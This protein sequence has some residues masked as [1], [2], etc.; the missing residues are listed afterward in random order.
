MLKLTNCN[1]FD[2]IGLSLQSTDNPSVVGVALAIA[3]LL[4]EKYGVTIITGS[5]MEDNALIRLLKSKF[6]DCAIYSSSAA[7]IAETNLL[8]FCEMYEKGVDI[9]K[10]PGTIYLRNDKLVCNSKFEDY[11]RS[12]KLF[13]SYQ[14]LM[15][16][17]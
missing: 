1:G 8:R 17:P 15:G 9:H 3:K 12:E 2:V 16:C 10:I 6:V 5:L 14:I 7:S 4:K 13:L 11:K